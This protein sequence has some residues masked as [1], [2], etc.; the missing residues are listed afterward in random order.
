M[1]FFVFIFAEALVFLAFY[2]SLRKG[3]LTPFPDVAV[4]YLAFLEMVLYLQVAG[5]IDYTF[6]KDFS[7]YEFETQFSQISAYICAYSF[8]LYFAK[9]PN[10]T[11][12]D[13]K[14]IFSQIELPAGFIF[15]LAVFFYIEFILF[16]FNVNWSNAWQNREYLLMTSVGVMKDNTP[17]NKELVLLISP[18]SL[19]SS[20]MFFLLLCNRNRAHWLF[21]PIFLWWFA[22]Q[23]GS[24]SRFAALMAGTGLFLALF[25]GRKWLATLLAVVTL[26]ALIQALTGRGAESGNGLSQVFNAL[27]LAVQGVTVNFDQIIGN[28]AGGIFVSA[29]AISFRPGLP[30]EYRLLSF[31]PLLNFIDHYQEAYLRVGVRLSSNAPASAIVE[32]ADFG[33]LYMAFYFGVQIYAGR[34]TTRLLTTRPGVVSV[35]LN[36][37]IMFG[38]AQQFAYPIRNAFR[39]SFYPI[40]ACFF[41]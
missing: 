26:V 15:G 41:L 29:E 1:N 12:V 10:G 23:L 4:L 6:L 39:W 11:K 34:L 31:S 3:P 8:I 36:N 14:K 16:A 2:M 5:I 35:M 19:L 21:M 22:Y 24:H 20:I 37:M 32:L 25:L 18:I 13:Y 40:V 30:L 27:P 9:S 28:A 7:K 17:L 38:F 33:A